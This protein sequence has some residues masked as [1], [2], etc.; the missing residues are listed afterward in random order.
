MH[1][2]L[3]IWAT[4]LVIGAF[5]I[6]AVTGIL[7]FFHIDIGLVHPAHEW[8]GWAMVAGVALHLMVNWRGFTRYFTQGAGR[9]VIALFAA[10]TIGAMLPIGGGDSPKASGGAV[11]RALHASSVDTVARVAKRSPQE[12][13]DAMRAS[14]LKADSTDQTI[15]ALARANDKEP[16]EVLALAMTPAKQ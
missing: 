15:E 7:M 13:L 8:L 6:S 2:T 12:V 14:G 3:R 1:P 16:M 11:I 4:P 5:L 10:L 9:A